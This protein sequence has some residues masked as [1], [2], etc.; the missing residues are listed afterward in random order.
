MF[1]RLYAAKETFDID[2][3]AWFSAVNHFK[4]VFICVHHGLNL[5]DEFHGFDCLV[6]T[7]ASLDSLE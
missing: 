6:L 7:L 4:D 1:R 2:L 3:I 5:F